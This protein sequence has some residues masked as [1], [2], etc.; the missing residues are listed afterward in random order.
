DVFGRRTG[1]YALALFAA[2]PIAVY[3][4]QE[5][6]HYGWLALFSALSWLIFLRYL[7]K[8]SRGLWI[9]YVLSITALIYTLYF[10]AFTLLMQGIVVLVVP[11]SDQRRDMARHA[12]TRNV[13]R[14]WLPF[15]LAWIAA[16]ILYI[17]WFYVIVTQQADIL[18]S[19]INGFP[20][21][22]AATVLPVLQT[23]FSAQIVIPL[24]AFLL[25]AGKILRRPSLPKIALLLGGGG[26]LLLM[27]I[28]SIKSDF[29]AARTLVFVTPLLMIVSGYGLSRI[30]WRVSTALVAVWIVATLALPQIVQPR[31]RSDLAGQA[32]ATAY[33]PG[34]A[35]ILEAGWDDNAFAYEISQALPAGASV[36]RTLPWTNDRTGGQPVVP[37]I[38][39][40]LQA[41][42]RVWI[43]QWLQAPQVLPFLQNGGDGFHAAQTLDVSAG[44]YGAQFSAPTIQIRLFVK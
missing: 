17:P 27:F 4:A 36:T 1:I 11:F 12:P 21:T 25:G 41:H 33:Q 31:L 19:G 44:A 26:L 38:E 7:R 22:L 9:A 8:P 14:Q 24:A 15:I 40:I 29:L 20:G 16:A 35:V 34:D 18:G 6:R 3:Y 28:L 37:Q 32:L 13:L 5:V 39:P 2:L 30:D 42:Q 10:G 23:V 43:V